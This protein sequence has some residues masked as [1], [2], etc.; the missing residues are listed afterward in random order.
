LLVSQEGLKP[1]EDWNVLLLYATV[2]A[3]GGFHAELLSV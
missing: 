1:G 2:L 3:L